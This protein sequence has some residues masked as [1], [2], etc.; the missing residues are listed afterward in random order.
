[1][2]KESP[3]HGRIIFCSGK[4]RRVKEGKRIYSAVKGGQT[5]FP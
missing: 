2:F 3:V 5:A 4:T 1:M